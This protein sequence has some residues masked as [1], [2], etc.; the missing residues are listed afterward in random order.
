MAEAL[1]SSLTAIHQRGMS[2]GRVEAA[3]VLATEETVKLRSDCLHITAAGQADDVAAI[4]PTCFTRSR[5]ARRSPLPMRKSIASRR[6][7]ARLFA[8][9]LPAAGRWRKSAMP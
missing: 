3:S 8:T 7:L 4:G 9:P 6:R 1:V 2:H 5:S